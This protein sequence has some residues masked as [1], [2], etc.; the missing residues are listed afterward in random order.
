MDDQVIQLAEQHYIAEQTARHIR[1]WGNQYQ[2]PLCP[3]FKEIWSSIAPTLRQPYVERVRALASSTTPTG[4]QAQYRDILKTLYEKSYA[5]MTQS[6]AEETWFVPLSQFEQSIGQLGTRVL[7]ESYQSLDIQ[8]DENSDDDRTVCSQDEDMDMAHTSVPMEYDP[9]KYEDPKI[10]T[11]ETAVKEGLLALNKLQQ[12]FEGSDVRNADIDWKPQIER[13]LSISQTEK[14]I[15][16]LNGSTGAGK[17]SLI[18]A[19]VDEEN[20]VATNCMR[21]S[22][23]V[24]TELLYNDGESRYKAQ[25]EFIELRDWEQELRILFEDLLDSHEDVIRGDLQKNSD[26][27]VALDKI[28]AVYPLLE[29]KD[30]LNTSV[31]A[32]MEHSNVSDLL[33]SVHVFEQ[34]DPKVFSRMVKSYIDSRGRRGRSEKGPEKGRDMK[35]WPLIRVVRIFL[36]APALITGAVLVDLPGLHDTNAARVEVAKEYSKR[37]S[38]HWIIT[39][40]NRA[41]DDKV[42]RDLLGQSFKM[43]MQMDCS[44][45]NITFVC[46]KTDHITVSE[47]QDSLKLR[48]PS[49]QERE[50]RDRKRAQLGAELKLLQEG[51]GRVMEE[52]SLLDDEIEELE[53]CLFNEESSLNLS[54]LT[55]IK[56]KRHSDLEKDVTANPNAEVPSTPILHVSATDTQPSADSEI[57]ELLRKF[58][59]LKSERKVLDTQRR[60]IYQQIQINKAALKRV[61]AESD[62]MRADTLRECIEA[63]NEYS[64]HEIKRDYANGIRDLDEEDQDTLA[65]S[66][67]SKLARNYKKIEDELP[68][69]LHPLELTRNF[70]LQRHCISLTERAREASAMRFLTQL[71]QLFQ[72][73]SLWSLETG[74]AHIMSAEEIQEL[75]A[76]QWWPN[77]DSLRHEFE[78]TIIR[79]F[80]PA[81][82]HASEK[83]PG[84]ISGWNAPRSEGGLHI[85]TYRATCRRRGMFRELDWNQQLVNPLLKRVIQGWTTMFNEKVPGHFFQLKGDLAEILEQYHRRAIAL[86]ERRSVTKE[87]KDMLDKALSICCPGTLARMRNLMTQEGARNSVNMLQTSARRVTKGLTSLLESTGADIEALID[88]TVDQVSRDY[89][90]AIIDPRVRKLSQQQIELKNKITNIIQTAETEVHL[91]QHLGLSNHQEL[92]AEI[93]KHEGVANIKDENMQA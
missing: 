59:S 17:S 90:I 47:V 15:I 9:R 64:K 14:V 79:R 13:T 2:L 41:V 61:Q 63:R 67:R 34:N 33:G 70:V 20:I 18:N 30:I 11:L 80:D 62:N 39:P 21:A 66:D 65:P 49:M 12:A 22:T 86:V 31:E 58:R 75:E 54:Q 35:Y 51:K 74:Q 6:V 78:K 55:P 68:C 37:C 43:Q 53:S 52:L 16:G 71:K 5:E 36:K 25:I 40:I 28:K 32:L 23:A 24:A 93:L 57:D 82:K 29:V 69:S 44:F 89:R 10:S 8:D 72:S 48:L 4:A 60:E 50:Q 45:N 83:I 85:Q 19:I 87:S 76:E 7:S 92:S 84:I 46:T 38:A 26:A 73:I 77:I 27:A 42:A 1:I 88:T 91:D 56:R 3:N 81:M